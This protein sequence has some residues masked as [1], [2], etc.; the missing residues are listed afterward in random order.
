MYEGKETM[1]EQ[2]SSLIP[3]AALVLVALVVIVTSLAVP[4]ALAASKY[5]TLYEFVG[6][7]DGSFPHARLVLDL[8]GNLY[9]TTWAGGAYSNGTV[10]QLTPNADGGWSKSVLHSFHITD[11]NTPYA[12]L[13]LDQ[14]GNLYGT[15]MFGGTYDYGAVF[16]L[17]PNGDGSW[18]EKVLHSFN[19]DFK[20]GSV[21]S[22]GLIFDKAG[23]LYGTTTGGGTYNAGTVF[24]LTPNADGSWQESILHS[25]NGY[26]GSAPWC[27]LILD[28]IGNLYGTT[29]YGGD[30]GFGTAFKLTP[31][32]G[33]WQEILLHSF[34]GQDGEMP[35]S[36]LIFDLTGNLYGT[37]IYGGPYDLRY[38]VVFEL[39]PKGND[40]WSETVLHSF[41]N[42][43]KDGFVPNADLIFD[44]SGN[45]YSTTQLGGADEYG[46]V[47]KLKR[48]GKGVWKETLVHSFRDHPGAT[49][50]AGLIFDGRGNLYGTT[51]GDG[52]TTFGT[53]FK[54]TP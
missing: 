49:S 32:G 39:T 37:T 30:S 50:F 21:L 9:G 31:N 36:G 41:N 25:F 2:N 48:G 47:F 14:A 22:G 7:L 38:G 4:C 1:N 43:G 19:N 28:R 35:I 24:R 44:W 52:K 10:F 20:D 54:V 5:K 27:D 40:G 16:E 13:I 15:T 23:N 51:A 33:G 34:T 11:G 46:T 18:S 8:S 29:I 3:S 6:G 42:D 26:D 53:V 17:S 45:L 12:G